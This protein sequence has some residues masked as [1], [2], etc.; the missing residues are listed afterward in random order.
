MGTIEAKYLKK[1]YF[2]EYIEKIE[3]EDIE[4]EPKIF[5]NL[6]EILIM[7]IKQLS[8]G[9]N[10]KKLNDK[11]KDKGLE[12]THKSGNNFDG[13]FKYL[14]NK[15]GENIIQQG[16]ISIEAS[17]N[18]YS[19]NSTYGYPENL[20]NYNWVHEFYSENV[21]N[22]WFEV[23]FKNNKVKI[24]GYSLKSANYGQNSYHLKNWVIE[25]SNDRSTWTEIDRKENNYDL[26][27]RNYQKYYPISQLTDEFQF[28]R[29]R[30][31]GKNHA[32]NNYL[33]LTNFEFYGEIFIRESI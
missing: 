32:N 12:I 4:R 6:K 11:D 22:S 30:N 28:I 8:L 9:E 15:Y 23:N 31:I 5:K 21:P 10:I 24:N 13:I 1:E 25:G 20:I 19:G 26:N 2:I 29:I 7:N 16:I 18:S 17:S 27:G 33:M 14:E 3:E